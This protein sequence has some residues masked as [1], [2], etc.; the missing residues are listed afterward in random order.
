M[1]LNNVLVRVGLRFSR[2]PD[3]ARS[4]SRDRRGEQY[5]AVGSDDWGGLCVCAATSEEGRGSDKR[6]EGEERE[7]EE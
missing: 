5:Q 6:R 2:I 1:V 4:Q 3:T 7:G